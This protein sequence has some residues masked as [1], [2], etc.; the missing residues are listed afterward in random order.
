[1]LGEQYNSCT[2]KITWFLC[3]LIVS[4]VYLN[5]VL[6]KLFTRLF[7]LLIIPNQIIKQC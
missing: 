1:M 2:S 5:I 3:F 6:F 4:S 7:G